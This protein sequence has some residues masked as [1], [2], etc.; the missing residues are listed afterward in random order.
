MSDGSEVFSGDVRGFSVVSQHDV[1]G[2]ID[3]EHDGCSRAGDGVQELI[4]RQLHT[5]GLLWVF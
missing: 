4:V 5:A 2:L 1:V 3:G